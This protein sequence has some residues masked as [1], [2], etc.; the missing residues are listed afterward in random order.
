MHRFWQRV[1]EGMELEQLW[2]QFVADAQSSYRLYS[3]ELVTDDKVPHHIRFFR[4]A[5]AFFWA[6]M[7]KLSPAKRLLLLIALVFLLFP[8][9]TVDQGQFTLAGANFRFL[10]GLILLV[11]LVLEV[12]ERVT[13]KRDLEI[14]REIQ[15]W[16]VPSAAPSIQGL[17][18][19]FINRP[20][21]TVAGD[22]YDVFFRRRPDGTDAP[23]LVVADVA[24]KSL[25]AALLMATF[26]ASLKTLSSTPCELTELVARVNQYA[27]AH[28]NGGL[29]FT[30]AFFAEIDPD[31]RRLRYVN[32]GHNLPMLRHA[33]GD[34]E[35]LDRG[36]L[37]LGIQTGA[38]YDLGEVQLSPAD[39]LLIFTDGLVEAENDHGKEYGEDSL[40][41]FMK[42]SAGATSQEALEFLMADVNRFVGQARQHDDI[43]CLLA[44][45]Q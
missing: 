6:V 12:A 31:N 36:G 45:I 25:P 26:Q 10:G 9:F 27:C 16:L 2:S 35:R 20:A 30:T 21:N 3:R 40:P 24:G 8:A 15:L 14:A 41:T 37:P 7:T 23:L 19:A 39:A 4:R 11:L 5:K 44:K 43:T 17:D 18:L 13:M 28:S 22:Y 32:A 1:T 42:A 33:T 34:C 38:P 29:R